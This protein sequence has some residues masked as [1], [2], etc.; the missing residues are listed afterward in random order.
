MEDILDYITTTSATL[1][2][3][4]ITAA[5]LVIIGGGCPIKTETIGKL[6]KYLHAV[7]VQWSGV[8]H[9]TI[10][11]YKGVR[12]ILF[13]SLCQW[14]MHVM[15]NSIKVYGYHS[16]N[17]RNQITDTTATC[18]HVYMSCMYTQHE[19]VPWFSGLDLMLPRS[20]ITLGDLITF[21]ERVIQ[22]V[23]AVVCREKGGRMNKYNVLYLVLLVFAPFTCTRQVSLMS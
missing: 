12:L 14:S 7:Q 19:L 11:I 4:G 15:C 21:M 18:M 22:S 6:S 17:Q 10:I 5:P 23:Q 3:T 13:F 9:K 16:F 1:N 20:F 2:V 8:A